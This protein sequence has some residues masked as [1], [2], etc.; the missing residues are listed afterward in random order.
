LKRCAPPFQLL[1]LALRATSSTAFSGAARYLFNRFF[2]RFALPSQLFC[3]GAARHLF[4][5]VY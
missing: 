1:F 4:N 2:W 3:L 5:R